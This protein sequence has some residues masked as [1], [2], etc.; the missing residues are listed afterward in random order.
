MVL[1]REREDIGKKLGKN[2]RSPPSLRNSLL[3]SGLAGISV[4]HPPP[5]FYCWL[6]FS[7]SRLATPPRG[8]SIFA[9]GCLAKAGQPDLVSKTYTTAR[10]EIFIK[11]ERCRQGL[12]NPFGI[13]SATFGG[14]VLRNKHIAQWLCEFKMTRTPAIAGFRLKC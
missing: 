7:R 4:S 12:S 6:S 3:L 1:R 5:Y 10:G 2:E 14:A 8:P 13:P 11:L 9:S